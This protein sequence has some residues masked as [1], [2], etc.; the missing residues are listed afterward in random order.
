MKNWNGRQSRV[1]SRRLAT[2]GDPIGRP[3]ADEIRRVAEEM[4]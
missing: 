4:R 1:D 3:L 2:A